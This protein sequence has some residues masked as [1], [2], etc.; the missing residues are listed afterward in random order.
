[1]SDAVVVHEP[2]RAVAPL[3]LDSPHSGEMYPA[4]FEHVASRANVRRH[5]R[6]HAQRHSLQVEVNRRLYMDG[7]TL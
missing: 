3:V 2:S 4:D 6:P 5:G 7:R 1:M